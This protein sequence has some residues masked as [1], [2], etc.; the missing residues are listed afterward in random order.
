MKGWTLVTV[1]VVCVVVGG[2]WFLQ[3]LGV[4]GGSFMSSSSTWLVIGLVL[5]VAG[6]AIVTLGARGLRKQV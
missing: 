5:A 3:G 6:L 2:V 1:G 4:I